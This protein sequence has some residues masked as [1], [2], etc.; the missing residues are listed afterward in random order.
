MYII[1]K[2]EFNNLTLLMYTEYGVKMLAYWHAPLNC[3]VR[4]RELE[5]GELDKYFTL[6]LDEDEAAK[7]QS[8]KVID[9]FVIWDG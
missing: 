6:D 8:D 3:W 7:F 5:L 2:S 4:L 9:N 1:F